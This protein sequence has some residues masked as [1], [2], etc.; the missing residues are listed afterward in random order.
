MIMYFD[1]HFQMNSLRLLARLLCSG[2]MEILDARHA[3]MHQIS[4]QLKELCNSLWK[5]VN[6][7]ILQSTKL[8]S[9]YLISVICL[10]SVLIN[11]IPGKALLQVPI[12]TTNKILIIIRRRLIEHH[13][14]N[15]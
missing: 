12:L 5:K 6:E 13:A 4:S 14:V 8:T 7:N 10:T 15:I 11:V 3:Q 9:Q 2:S 1:L